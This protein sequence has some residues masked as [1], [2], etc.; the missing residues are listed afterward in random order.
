[1]LTEIVQGDTDMSYEDLKRRT[2]VQDEAPKRPK[3]RAD[4]AEDYDDDDFG[5]DY[6]DGNQEAGHSNVSNNETES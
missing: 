1:M 2:R 3:R 5:D 6:V 4:I